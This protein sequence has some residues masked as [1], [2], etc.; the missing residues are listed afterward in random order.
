M[1][2]EDPNRK[3]VK[4]LGSKTKTEDEDNLGEE[5]AVKFFKRWK[6]PQFKSQGRLAQQKKKQTKVQRTKVRPV[7]ATKI[8]KS[9]RK[10]KDQR[11]LIM[12]AAKLGR[13]F[14]SCIEI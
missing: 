12:N 13:K 2:I 11:D 6:S 14:L 10:S 9:T 3:G 1:N 8:C 5:I 7:K 4:D